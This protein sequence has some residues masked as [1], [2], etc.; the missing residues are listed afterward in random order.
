MIDA[1]EI[2]PL[3]FFRYGGVYTGEHGDNKG[4][5][6]RLARIGEKPDFKLCAYAWQG[7]FAYDA[8]QN[9]KVDKK[10]FPL[11]EEGRLEAVCWLSELYDAKRETWDSA[12]SILSAAI[13][14]DEMYQKED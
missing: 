3:N 1:K 4:M 12:P 10:E 6:Y 2:M 14:L 5:R 8:M 13:R 9:E 7:P 11:T